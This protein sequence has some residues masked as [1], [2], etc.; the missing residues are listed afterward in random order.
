MFFRL[1][2]YFINRRHNNTGTLICIVFLHLLKWLLVQKKENKQT[3]P[4]F[5][6]KL[7]NRI[8]GIF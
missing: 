3:L 8:F 4:I 7:E 1:S 6:K 2:I 5:F